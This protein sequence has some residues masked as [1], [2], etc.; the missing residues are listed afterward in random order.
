MGLTVCSSTAAQDIQ[1]DDASHLRGAIS[2]NQRKR[3]YIANDDH[4][5]YFWS[6]TDEDYRTVF[7]SM[8]DFYMDQ[9][10][11]TAAVN[12][13]DSRG[14]F[15]CDGSLWV[16]VY[17]QN[18]TA[19]EFDRLVDHL[20]D[21]T[22][23]M[24]LNTLPLLYGAMP[25]EAVLRNMYYAGMLER[26][27]GVRFRL[28][29]PMENQVLPAGVAS[30]WAGSGAL[31]SWKGICSCATRIDATMRQ[32]EIYFF[33]G[34][35]G[36]SV[37][38]KWNSMWNWNNESIGGYA[39]ARHPYEVVPFLDTN[40]DFLAAWPWGVSAAFGYGWDDLDSYTDELIR[41]S[42][43][44]S[45]TD[46]RVIVSN[47]IDFFEDFLSHYSG[48]IPTFSGSFGNEW[49]LYTA[50]MAAVTAD[51]RNGI[52]RLRTA[53]ALATVSSIYDTTFMNGRDAAR[54]DAFIA[55]GLFYD[56]DWCANSWI[57][58]QYR[59]QFERD[60][61]TDLESYVDPLL[62]DGIE[63]VGALIPST[64]GTERFFVFNPLSWVRT[65]FVDLPSSQQP[66]LHVV[67]IASGLEVPSQLINV[68]SDQRVRIIADAVPS[69]GYRV[70]EVRTGEGSIF[71]PSATIS[72]PSFDNS[73]YG[74]T[75][76]THGEIT[77]LIDHTDGDRQIVGVSGSIHDIGTG[78]GSVVVES[79]GPVSTTL[80]VQAGGSPEHETRVTLYAGIDRVDIDGA[81]TEN[82]SSNQGYTSSFNLSGI[83]MRHEETGMI[84]RVGRIVDGGDYADEDARTDYLTFNHFVDLSATNRGVTISNRDSPFFRAGNSTV[85][86]L[87]GS[88][89]EIR[90]VIGMRVDGPYLGI[91]D[92]G[93]DSLF[94][95]RFAIRAHGS[96]DQ[97][98]AMRFSMEHQNPL[99]AGAITGQPSAPLPADSMTVVSISNENVLLWALKPAEEGI[100]SGIIVRVWNLADAP[101][102][103]DL[104]LPYDTIDAAIRTTHIET[105]IETAT[106]VGGAL[107]DTLA[108]Q[109]MRTYRLNPGS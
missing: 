8:L 29:V 45:N 96:Y 95:D 24:P 7:L 69:S 100:D 57:G 21:G 67:D 64:V 33:S 76:G 13:P 73:I 74:V 9:A 99:V 68:D 46:L 37:C 20:R 30:L 53:E 16:R 35:D 62:N 41:A 47:E 55:C 60:M 15:N 90:A 31:Y 84:A 109:E 23:T 32:H 51:F 44:L 25:A 88:T 63:A 85:S 5:D 94:V 81:V 97:A 87:D 82:F 39:E 2:V 4:T 86:S 79:A 59:A 49:D 3:I 70:Y 107:R 108:R 101:V 10:E 103:F 38:M 56:H 89:P 66:P 71:P 14:R 102:T 58:T 1:M 54:E 50:S 42:V 106:L 77:S 18:K 65:D 28:V 48:A 78:N 92:Q 98:A 27:E 36:Q 26:R 72:L 52:E 61:L 105:E 12:P 40:S 6:G 43:D 34:P 17:E 19:P 83:E 11:S 22:I 75:L 91:A 104:A 80:L 93:G